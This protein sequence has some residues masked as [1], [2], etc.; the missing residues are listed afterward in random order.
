MSIQAS[1][2]D[3]QTHQDTGMGSEGQNQLRG[4]AEWQ[5]PN[6]LPPATIWE[7]GQGEISRAP[8]LPDSWQR[9]LHSSQ[10]PRKEVLRPP[11]DLALRKEAKI[12]LRAEN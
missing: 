2:Q 3:P 8:S 10:D 6:S 9:A 12:K 1:S 11:R 7:K 4:S 5:I